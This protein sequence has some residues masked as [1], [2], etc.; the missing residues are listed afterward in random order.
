MLINSLLGYK[1]MNSVERSQRTGLTSACFKQKFLFREGRCM[2]DGWLGKHSWHTWPMPWAGHNPGLRG[3]LCEWLTVCVC[4]CQLSLFP[5]RLPL[6]PLF[7]SGRGDHFSQQSP[8]WQRHS[9]HIN[10]FLLFIWCAVLLGRLRSVLR[11]PASQ[12][13]QIVWVWR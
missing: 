3:T 12:N 5:V 2:G 7:H 6:P 11:E 1:E 9:L 13:T 8:V 4:V 10:P